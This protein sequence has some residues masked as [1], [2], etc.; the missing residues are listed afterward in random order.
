[1]V[2]MDY[3]PLFFAWLAFLGCRSKLG[4]GLLQTNKQPNALF[5]GID[6]D[7]RVNHVYFFF[8]AAVIA[9]AVVVTIETDFVTFDSHRF[10][11]E[12]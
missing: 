7:F 11:P 10:P 8:F 2:F 4:L 5:H 3:L 9:V 1:M 6:A 12:A